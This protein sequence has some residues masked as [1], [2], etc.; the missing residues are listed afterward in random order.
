MHWVTLSRLDSLKILQTGLAQYVEKH[1]AEAELNWID[2]L[3]QGEL[4]DFKG[5]CC[6]E[7]FSSPLGKYKKRFSIQEF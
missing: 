2:S 5:S 6:E 3:K 1:A 4:M 7:E